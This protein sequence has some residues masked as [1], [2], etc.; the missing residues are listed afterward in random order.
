[1]SPYGLSPFRTR[2][3]SDIAVA[4]TRW[5]YVSFMFLWIAA[6]NKSSHVCFDFHPTPQPTDNDQNHAA[7]ALTV[8]RKD[9]ISVTLVLIKEVILSRANLLHS[10]KFQ[11]LVE[12]SRVFNRSG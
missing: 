7:F 6:E 8:A 12:T 10:S 11:R 2:K 9:I 3:I 5:E 4:L 1:M